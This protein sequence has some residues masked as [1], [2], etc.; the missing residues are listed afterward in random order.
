MRHIFICCPGRRSGNPPVRRTFL[1]APGRFRVYRY[2]PDF[3]LAT[4]TLQYYVPP[5]CGIS[6]IWIVLCDRYNEQFP[7][8]F[9][10]QTTPGWHTKSFELDARK[11]QMAAWDT[12]IKSGFGEPRRSEGRL[13]FFDQPMRVIG[14][15]GICQVNEK[16]N[17]NGIAF[18]PITLEVKSSQQAIRPRL[19]TGTLVYV[20]Q[21]GDEQ[22]LAL[23]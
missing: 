22:K 6:S 8:R 21:K 13:N 17:A 12:S 3:T 19:E 14:I 5:K 10:P 23:T 2:L 4:L 16:E 18:G 7:L 15:D 11:I 20:L 1:S 9:A